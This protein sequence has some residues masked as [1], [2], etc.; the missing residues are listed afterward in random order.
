MK[1]KALFSAS[2]DIARRTGVIN[3]CYRTKDGRFI[4]SENDLSPIRLVMLPDEYVNGL[5]VIKVT[6]E[7]AKRLIAENNYQ[8]GEEYLE[9]NTDETAE[10]S[11]E[12]ADLV[13][14]EQTEEEE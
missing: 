12:Y 10:A 1:K 5:D 3:T 4:L 6:D 7:E 2:A 14:D 11:A 8:I 13:N 9:E